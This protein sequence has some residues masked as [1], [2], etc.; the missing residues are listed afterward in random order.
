MTA[1]RWGK[2]LAGMGAFVVLFFGVVAT[3]FADQVL[4]DNGDRI[5]GTVN[6]LAAGELEVSTSYA[7]TINVAWDRVIE[8]EAAK[9]MLL[10]SREDNEAVEVQSTHI[11]RQG[12]LFLVDGAGDT[13]LRIRSI[14]PPLWKIGK[15]YRLS[16]TLETSLKMSRS[17]SRQDEADVTASMEWQRLQHRVRFDGEFEYYMT[18]GLKTADQW[19]LSTKY[20]NIVSKQRY[21]GVKLNFKHDSI[22]L[23]DL[24]FSTGSYI[25]QQ[26]LD[27]KGTLLSAE[28][29]CDY[30]SERMTEQPALSKAAA[31]WAVDY[32]QRLFRDRFTF[33]HRQKGLLKFNETGGL[34]LD[35]WT[36][37]RIPVNDRFH[38][39]LELK[40]TY[41]G[42]TPAGVQPWE[43]KYMLK[44]GYSW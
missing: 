38:T 27:H 43:L 19:D 18:D 14:N 24:R 28:L 23:L 33:Y 42:D 25:G 40:S 5:A 2:G 8:I 16:G 35:T 30:V 3:G 12:S 29:G 39:S 34:V 6:S 15:G 32:S 31:S 9:P 37:M 22:A 11:K 41:T 17:I 1:G 26:L 36:G 20:D 4:L 13:P 21:Y 7:G 10:L 44:V